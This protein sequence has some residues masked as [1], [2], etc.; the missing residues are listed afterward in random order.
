MADG[1]NSV[2]QGPRLMIGERSF[3]QICTL[4]CF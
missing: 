4:G 1:A 3:A 2:P